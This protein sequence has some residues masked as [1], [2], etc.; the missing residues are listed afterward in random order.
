MKNGLLKW[1]RKIYFKVITSIA[2]YP[3]LIALI[4]LVLSILILEFDFSETG[5]KI[6][7]DLH[8]IRLQDANTALSIVSTI[9][10]GMVSLTVFSFS[11]V[12]LL[13]NQTV[14]Q[15]SNR[16]LQSMI[17][18]RFQQIVLG[19]Y[20]GSIV[21]GLFLLSSIRTSD[22]GLSVPVI[23]IYVLVLLMVTDIFFFIYF[24]HYVTQMVKYETIID[25]IHKQTLRCMKAATSENIT[26]EMQKNSLPETEPQLVYINA[27]DYFQGFNRKELM[28]FSCS[29]NMIIEFMHPAGTYLL[30]GMPLL[31]I[32]GPDRLDKKEIHELFL[33]I[34]T[35]KGQPVQS[36]YY[37]GFHQ[38]AEVA[39]KALSPGI[40][41]PQTAVL[42]L[43]AITDLLE[44]HLHHTITSTYLDDKNQVRIITKPWNFESLFQ[45][46]F[47]PIWNYGKNDQYVQEAMLEMTTQL[48]T[49]NKNT[50]LD[51]ILQRFVIMLNEHSKKTGLFL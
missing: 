14:S 39:V 17:S 8:F 29:K 46:C 51:A 3:A 47:Y 35:Y 31:K 16:M 36:N 34:D 13:L 38:L 37:Y 6:K 26:E 11:M 18:N 12:M 42:S 20:I 22:N 21:Y 45:T 25:K 4:F 9:L 15:M 49:C 27:S 2:F 48:K 40:N 30:K 10:T 1:I 24:L 43:H 23:S 19:F 7:S 44:Y 32:Y 5:R 28:R 41:D 50:N 33:M